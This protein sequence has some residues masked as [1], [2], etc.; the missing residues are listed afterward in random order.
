MK[1]NYIHVI[2]QCIFLPGTAWI[3]S[4]WNRIDG[5]GFDGIGVD[6]MG[7]GCEEME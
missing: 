4:G 7:F 1:L 6:R 3:G 5:M 2:S